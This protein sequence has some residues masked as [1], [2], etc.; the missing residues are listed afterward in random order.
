MTDLTTTATTEQKPD[1]LSRPL[2]ATLNIDWEKAIYIAFIV[3]AIV[4][5]FWD[6]GSRVMSHD[7]SLHTQFSYQFYRGD[8]FQHTPLMHGPFLFHV[9]AVSYWLFGDNDLAARIPVAIM[10]VLL[11]AMPYLLRPWLGRIGALFTSFFFLISPFITYYS[12]Y[13]RHDIFVIVWAMIVFIATL[14]Y[15]RERKEKYLWWFAAGVALMFSTK[16]VA[17]IY[18]AIFGSFLVMRLAVQLGTAQ[19]FSY[20]LPK[21]RPALLILLVAVLLIGG[22]FIGQQASS[23]QVETVATEE[24]TQG[25]FAA[26]PD[27]DVTATAQPE[28]GG[29]STLLRWAQIVGV[30]LLSLGLFLAVQEMRPRIDAFPEFDLILLFTTLILPMASPFLTQMAG[31]NPRDYSLSTCMLEGQESMTAVQLFLAR[32]GNSDCWSSFLSSGLVRSG[33]F[34][35]LTLAVAILV[36]LWWNRRRWLVAAVIFHSIFIVLYTS[37]FTHPGGWASGMI[38]SLAYWLEQ[39]GVARGNQPGFYYFFIVPF[40]EFLPLIFAL[41]AI[42]LWEKRHQLN[43]IVGHWLTVIL[44]AL[45]AF[46]LTNWLFNRPAVEV[47]APTTVVPGLVLGFLILAI[48]VLYWFFVRRKQ[49][50]DEY[51]LRR[52]FKGLVQVEAMCELVPFLTW[53]FILTWVAYSAAGEKM[54]WLSTHFV[55][56]MALLGGWYFAQKLRD[57]EPQALLS[58]RSLV[59]LGVTAVLIVTVFL[60]IGPLLLGQIRLGNQQLDNLRGIGRFLGGLVAAGILYYFWQQLYERV[61]SRLRNAIVVPSL[62]LLLSLLTVRFTYMANFPNADYATEFL[63]YAHSAPATKNTVLAQIEELSMRLHGDK[64]LRVAFG[65]SGVSWPFTWY[66]REYPNRNYFAENPS[67]NLT[68]SPIIIAGRSQWGEVEKYLGNNYEQY[69]YT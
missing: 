32:L 66:L 3:L 16:E 11:V 29:G 30:G 14:Y 8:G 69:T 49:L 19:W 4:S 10:G 28:T 38:G 68:E 20:V 26:D 59:L 43:K 35:L 17:F 61:S 7:E 33:F 41:A 13:I 31:W 34:L 21:L 27:E 5:R 67:A 2:L 39:Q 44:V 18:V 50:L 6:L 15:L 37:V 51:G 1:L 42:R 54:P 48:G 57:I 22:G 24:A 9:T 45:L 25:G 65:G 36:G 60:A 12:R 63:V 53:W 58:R 55:I 56:P 52:N 64:S 40:Y 62:F 46:S 47:G 23:R